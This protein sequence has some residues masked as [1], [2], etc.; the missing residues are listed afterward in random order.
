[1]NES[2]KRAAA[3]GVAFIAAIAALGAGQAQTPEPTVSLRGDLGITDSSPP[4]ATV[5]QAL[6]NDGFGRAFRQQPPLI[7]HRI[8]G[9]QVSKDYNKCMS[10]HD[11][12]DYT[13]VGAP[14]ISETHYRDRDNKPLD[15]VS[16]SRWFCTQCH[17]P[18][19]DTPD[20]VDNT[21]RSAV[22]N[23]AD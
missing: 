20:L 16:N 17:V 7:P 8:D 3:A 12:P 22:E 11:W 18:Q 14:K 9:Y 10:C 1:M 15:R 2:A 19:A 4:P 5:K 21:F 23:G 6:S 13:K